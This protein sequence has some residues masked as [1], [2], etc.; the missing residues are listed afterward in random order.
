MMSRYSLEVL[1]EI[2]KHPIF[3]P[4]VRKLRVHS[5]ADMTAVESSEESVQAVEGFIRDMHLQSSGEATKLLRSAFSS[6]SEYA[7]PL[8]L[9]SET[10]YP[11]HAD[12]T[13][14][15]PIGFKRK[16][17][18]ACRKELNWIE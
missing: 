6:L 17:T 1:D 9:C 8:I 7:R 12:K 14:S 10:F 2:C 3:G 4:R 13:R 16:A 18:S 15:A 5:Y 11:D